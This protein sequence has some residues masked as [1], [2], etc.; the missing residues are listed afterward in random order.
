MKRLILILLFTCVTIE[1]FSQTSFTLSG[2]INGAD[3]AM[4]MLAYT[5]TNDT[6]I[7]DS[8]RLNNGSFT[9]KGDVNGG[10]LATISIYRTNAEKDA[11][12]VR[13]F[14]E[15]G[16]ITAI[17]DFGK[18]NETTFTGSKSQLE[19]EVLQAQ[20]DAFNK[21]FETFSAG[22]NKVYSSYERAKK[23]NA[24][25]KKLDSIY[26]ILKPLQQQREV[27]AAKYETITRDFIVS[28]PNSF[29][30]PF[31]MS[32]YTS[33]WPVDS[34]KM[35]FN[36]FSPAVQYS[37]YGTQIR[38]AIAAIDSKSANTIAPNFTAVELN[39]KKTNLSDFKGKYVLLDFWASWCLPCRE[40]NPHLIE[41]YKKYNKAGFD[42]IA[43]AEDD[44]AV[45]SWKK[46]IQKDGTSLWHN[47]LSGRQSNKSSPN[48]I[49]YKFSIGALPTKIL[50]DKNG[51]IIGRYM[52]AD[53]KAM[54]EKLAAIFGK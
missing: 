42:V 8:C 51:I 1:A 14:L 54:D 47:V 31:E 18:L 3:G 16:I 50:I 53:E 46:A 44:D 26:K 36:N 48:S 2:K 20:V 23:D 28:H 19:Y 33:I 35:L 7:T 43:I 29:V 34:V 38:K 24:P 32:V 40:S 6:P 10:F 9:F 21:S 41:L 15:P 4:A 11:N 13:F 22:F 27:Y 12:S 39:G 49:T 37:Y 52:E 25:D 30:S 17:G 45:T 5:N